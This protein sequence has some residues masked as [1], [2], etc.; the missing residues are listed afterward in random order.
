MA[1]LYIIKQSCN[2]FM[3]HIVSVEMPLH[4][5]G[6]LEEKFYFISILGIHYLEI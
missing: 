3:I 5:C 1:Y 6:E 4:C 2:L